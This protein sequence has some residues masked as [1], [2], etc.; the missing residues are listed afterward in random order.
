MSVNFSWLKSLGPAALTPDARVCSKHF[1]GGKFKSETEAC[2]PVP[3]FGKK[4]YETSNRKPPVFRTGIDSTILF[5]ASGSG[6][7]STCLTGEAYPS[8]ASIIEVE[9]V[10]KNAEDST[11]KKIQRLQTEKFLLEKRIQ[12]LEDKV[13]QNSRQQLT[14]E[15]V[16]TDDE[17]TLFYTGFDTAKKLVSFKN[18]VG[19]PENYWSGYQR[20]AGNNK[21]RPRK[22]TWEDELLLYLCRLRLNLLEKDLSYR[23]GV[24]QS[25]VSD[26]VITWGIHINKILSMIDWWV[27]KENLPQFCPKHLLDQWPTTVAILDC[28]AAPT[29]CP[30]NLELQRILW[31]EYYHMHCFKFLVSISLFGHINFVSKLFPGSTTDVDMVDKSDILERLSP[32]DNVMV[33]KGFPIKAT[34]DR[35]EVT[36][37]IPSKKYKGTQMS[38]TD[39]NKSRK[40]SSTSMSVEQGIRR[41]KQYLYV[42]SKIPLN[43][44]RFASF[45]MQNRCYLSNFQSPFVRGTQDLLTLCPSKEASLFEQMYTQSQ[46]L[47]MD[48]PC[49]PDS[50][51]TLAA[52]DTSDDRLSAVVDF[53]DIS[54]EMFLILSTELQFEGVETENLGYVDFSPVTCTSEPRTAQE[55]FDFIERGVV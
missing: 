35:L 53:D 44:N 48:T 40:I 10:D 34:L 43:D 23:F 17:M 46:S 42:K 52:V 15:V 3:D 55:A 19:T 13:K 26:L 21:G 18:L 20:K 30:S 32:G 36:M 5:P 6:D 7:A 2:I 24:C 27:P 54:P 33:D 47:Q 14:F 37:N 29:E 12:E 49:T 22:I 11:S 25:L 41:I 51:T 1:F 28:T 9:T 4:N 45:H 16:S 38:V 39:L 31:S 8:P 50:E